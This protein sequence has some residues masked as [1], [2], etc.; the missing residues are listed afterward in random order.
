MSNTPR[1]DAEIEHAKNFVLDIEGSKPWPDVTDERY[2][3]VPANFARQ[4]ERELNE[5]VALM[6]LAKTLMHKANEERDKLRAEVEVLRT[7]VI[8]GHQ[9]YEIICAD[10]APLI[11]R[12][13]NKPETTPASWRTLALNSAHTVRNERNAWR[14]DAENLAEVIEGHSDALRILK[15]SAALAAHDKLVKEQK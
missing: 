12:Q 13:Y 11:W 4:L 14:A 2:N 1:T 15:V 3:I 5:A 7:L 9:H 10:L 6:S 8:H